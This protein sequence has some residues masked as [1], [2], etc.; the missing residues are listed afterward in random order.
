MLLFDDE[1]DVVVSSAGAERFV[2]LEAG[3]LPGDTYE[4]WVGC[5]GPA[6]FR[7]DV[8]WSGQSSLTSHGTQ[9]AFGPAYSPA[10]QA[11]TLAV[12]AEVRRRLAKIGR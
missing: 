11:R 6:A 2:R 9:T 1:A 3:L 5:T 12:E 10:E 8:S 7:F 4:L